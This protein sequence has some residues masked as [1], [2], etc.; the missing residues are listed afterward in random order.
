MCAPSSPWRM[1]TPET[2]MSALRKSSRTP[3][4]DG[5]SGSGAATS[6]TG[7]RNGST[8]TDGSVMALLLAW[9]FA[10][11][12]ERYYPDTASLTRSQAPGRPG[13]LLAAQATGHGHV[14]VDGTLIET[15]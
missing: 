5:L 3:S 8:F 15:D 1:R 13:A 10:G 12:T 4:T 7:R 11:D 14:N 6:C 2:S 9:P